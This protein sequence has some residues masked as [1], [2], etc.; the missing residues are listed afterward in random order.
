MLTPEEPKLLTVMKKR[1]TPTMP[2]RM[3]VARRRFSGVMCVMDA[4]DCVGRRSS[5]FFSS[6][7]AMM[8]RDPYLSILG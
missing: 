4:A 8:R 2:I 1:T 7:N 3:Y 6:N 5:C